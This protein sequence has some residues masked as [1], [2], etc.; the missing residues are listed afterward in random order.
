[1]R[2]KHIFPTQIWEASPFHGT[3]TQLAQPASWPT[4]NP[5]PRLDQ[6]GLHPTNGVNRGFHTWGCPNNWMVYFMENPIY[7]WMIWRYPHFRKPSNHHELQWLQIIPRWS[8]VPSPLRLRSQP[9]MPGFTLE[10]CH[11]PHISA[12]SPFHSQSNLHKM[13]RIWYV[14]IYIHIYYMVP[15]S[16]SPPPQWVEGGALPATG[17]GKGKISYGGSR[18]KHAKP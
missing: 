13:S 15:S 5:W 8:K 16:V 4:N 14:Y 7:K 2:K 12:W 6:S 10:N 18:W 17:W 1:M 3:F 9:T 11:D